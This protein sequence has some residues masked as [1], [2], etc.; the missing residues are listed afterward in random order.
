MF[1]ARFLLANEKSCFK[2]EKKIIIMGEK[3]QTA[4]WPLIVYIFL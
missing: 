3:Q 4:F 2:Y 1:V